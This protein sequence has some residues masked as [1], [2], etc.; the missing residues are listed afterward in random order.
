[1]TQ[2]SSAVGAGDGTK[3]EAPGVPAGKVAVPIATALEAAGKLYLSG[4][5]ADAE[6][7]CRQVIER[8]PNVSDA[9]NLLGVVMSAQGDFAAAAVPLARA[10]TLE[11][12][13]ASIR[14]AL[15]RALFHSQRY[16]EALEEFAALAAASPTDDYAQFC[17]GR[18]LQQLGR[19]R[20]ACGPLAIAACLR[21]ERAEYRVYRDRAREAAARG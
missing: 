1:M 21:P 7:V 11:P 19:H 16:R 20:E 14:E 6:R 15:G 10:R 12:D 5:L 13:K 3:A 17:L 9:Y 2:Q 8:R 18:A 4:R